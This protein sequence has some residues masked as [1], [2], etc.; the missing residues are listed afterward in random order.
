LFGWLNSVIA[1]YISPSFATLPTT[2]LFPNWTAQFASIGSYTLDWDTQQYKCWISQWI[3]FGLL[4]ALQ[5]LNLFWLFLIFRVAYRF[6]VQKVAED[7]RSEH[8]ESDVEEEVF[9]PK[10]KVYN[11]LNELDGLPTVLLNGE[12]VVNDDFPVDKRA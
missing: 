5:S 12:P 11:A 8:G 10:E 9:V 7:E 3:T 6:A 4:A 2:P 1:H